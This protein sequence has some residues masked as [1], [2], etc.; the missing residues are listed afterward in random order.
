M[1]AEDGLT[2]T[3]QHEAHL[4]HLT[5]GRFV[6]VVAHVIVIV[7][8]GRPEAKDVAED[9]HNPQQILHLSLVA[10]GKTVE[11]GVGVL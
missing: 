4:K 3:S 2:E 1:L 8:G 9:S 5:A 6:P 7:G 10:A 11:E